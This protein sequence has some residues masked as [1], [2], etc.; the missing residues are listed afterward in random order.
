MPTH[1]CIQEIHLI[2]I[3]YLTLLMLN[4]RRLENHQLHILPTEPQS[5]HEALK[6]QG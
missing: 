2:P 6:P 1:A 4:K 3:K 5:K